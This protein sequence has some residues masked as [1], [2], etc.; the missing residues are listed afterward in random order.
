MDAATKHMF[1]LV[2]DKLDNMEKVQNE[3]FS[4]VEERLDKIEVR[5]NKIEERLD[6]V[7]ERLLKS[8]H[9]ERIVWLHNGQLIGDDTDGHIDTIVRLA[10]NDTIIYNGQITFFIIKIYM[11][12]YYRSIGRNTIVYNICYCS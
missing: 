12:V 3:R 4:K 8:L 7:E 10:P 2:L 11:N 1:D 6:K 5:L 9:A